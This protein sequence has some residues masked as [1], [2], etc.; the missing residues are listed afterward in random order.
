MFGLDIFQHAYI[1]VVYSQG[2]EYLSQ[3]HLVGQ[4]VKAF[5]PRVEGPEFES[6]LW[7]DFSGSNH[8]SDLKFGTLVATPPGAWRYSVSAGTGRPGVSIL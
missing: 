5:A 2:L 6:R 1:F 3:H 7:W 4:V 8:T